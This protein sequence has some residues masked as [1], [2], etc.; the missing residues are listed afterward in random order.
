M[1]KIILILSLIDISRCI[2]EDE[3]GIDSESDSHEVEKKEQDAE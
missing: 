1:W 3:E 2:K